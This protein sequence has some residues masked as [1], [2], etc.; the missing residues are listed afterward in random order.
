MAETSQLLCF[1]LGCGRDGVTPLSESYN[2]FESKASL[3]GRGSGELFG[4]SLVKSCFRC[5]ESQSYKLSVEEAKRR[6]RI[7]Y[8]L[9]D[10]LS[11]AGSLFQEDRDYSEW[12]LVLDADF[13]PKRTVDGILMVSDKVLEEAGYAIENNHEDVVSRERKVSWHW[14]QCVK[15][16]LR[17]ERFLGGRSGVSDGGG[18]CEVEPV[19]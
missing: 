2:G 1:C 6:I 8:H 5:I 9:S 19:A 15:K 13:S 4:V 11:A 3:G 7:A 17:V 14:A 16:M 12:Y 10:F 18:D